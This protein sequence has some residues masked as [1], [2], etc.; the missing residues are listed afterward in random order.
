M[1]AETQKPTPLTG[2]QL[3]KI[4]ETFSKQMQVNAGLSDNFLDRLINDDDDW[5]FV[6]R[7]HAL[8]EAAFNEFLVHALGR[9]SLSAVIPRM[10][11]GGGKTGKLAMAKA[12]GG[13]LP[14]TIQF[15][16]KFSDLRNT[17]VH[18]VTNTSFSSKQYFS[19]LTKTDREAW[20][21]AASL[22]GFVIVKQEAGDSDVGLKDLIAH[23]L[24]AVLCHLHLVSLGYYIAHSA[25]RIALMCE[26]KGE[27]A[28]PIF[29][30]ARRRPKDNDSNVAPTWS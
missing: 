2:E 24:K 28:R 15:A 9:A 25:Q 18:H 8:L 19:G 10:Q 4:V 21:K 13:L 5:S 26:P 29:E 6:V 1:N 23:A 22:E 30:L 12:I 17:F 20:L 16:E 14:G 3:H 11:L 27:A 7:G